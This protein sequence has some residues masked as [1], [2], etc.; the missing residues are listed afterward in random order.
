MTQEEQQ[1]GAIHCEYVPDICTWNDP[2]DH[3]RNWDE[4]SKIMQFMYQS[5]QVQEVQPPQPAQEDGEEDVP[6]QVRIVCD[7]NRITDEV[8]KQRIVQLNLQDKTFTPQKTFYSF[9]QTAHRV[10]SPPFPETRPQV[11]QL[12]VMLNNPQKNAALLE[13]KRRQLLANDPNYQADPNDQIENSSVSALRY[14]LIDFANI[15]LN[16]IRK[17]QLA[18]RL[19]KLIYKWQSGVPNLN[20]AVGAMLLNL[21]PRHAVN[22][23]A[24]DLARIRDNAM[25]L[26][27]EYMQHGPN[28]DLVE[29][30]NTNFPE[31]DMQAVVF[32]YD[33][34]CD[35][36]RQK[37]IFCRLHMQETQGQITHL[38]E[39]N[40]LKK[41]SSELDNLIQR[42]QTYRPNEDA[43][44]DRKIESVKRKA[45]EIINTYKEFVTLEESQKSR[46]KAKLILD[47]LVLIF[48]ECESL[49]IAGINFDKQTLGVDPNE[50][51]TPIETLSI[52]IENEV[53]KNKQREQQMQINAKQFTAHMPGIM[54]PKLH[55]SKDYLNFITNYTAIKSSIQDKLT[56]ANLIKSCLVK[57][58]DIEYLAT[59]Y[60][61][62][63]ILTYIRE[64][65]ADHNL[66]VQKSLDELYAMKNCGS[67]VACM[68][69]N[70]DKFRNLLKLFQIHHLL[71]K[72]DR[73]ARDRLFPKLFLDWQMLMFAHEQVKAEQRWRIADKSSNANTEDDR[74]REGEEFL[75]PSSSLNANNM[76]NL[77][78]RSRQDQRRQERMIEQQNACIEETNTLDNYEIGIGEKIGDMESESDTVLLESRRRKFFIRQH[79]R[80]YEAAMKIKTAEKVQLDK[81]DEKF[82][83]RKQTQG[84]FTTQ[85][86]G[87]PRRPQKQYKCPMFSCSKNGMHR[88]SLVNCATF[89]A[90]NRDEKWSI[91]SK[92][93][94][95]VCKRCLSYGHNIGEHSIVNGKCPTQ[96]KYRNLYCKNNYCIRAGIQ[97]NH[98][99]HICKFGETK[100][101]Q[102]IVHAQKDGF[103]RYNPKIRLQ[104]NY[105]QQQ[106]F[107]RQQNYGIQNQGQENQKRYSQSSFRGQTRGTFPNRGR[108]NF[109]TNNTFPNR[110][111]GN[112]QTNNRTP[113]TDRLKPGPGPKGSPGDSSSRGRGGYNRGGR[114]QYKRQN[115]NARISQSQKAYTTHT[116]KIEKDGCENENECEM[117]C[118]NPM[119]SVHMIENVSNN[120]ETNEQQCYMVRDKKVYLIPG[121][122]ESVPTHRP[123]PNKIEQSTIISQKNKKVKWVKHEELE[124]KVK[125]NE[126]NYETITWS[127]KIPQSKLGN[128]DKRFRKEISLTE[129][130]LNNPDNNKESFK[131]LR[132]QKRS[133][134]DEDSPEI[135][136][137]IEDHVRK[138]NKNKIEIGISGLEDNISTQTGDMNYLIDREKWGTRDKKNNFSI[139]E[140]TLGERNYKD[141]C[142]NWNWRINRP[143]YIGDRAKCTTLFCRN[144]VPWKDFKCKSCFQKIEK[145]NTMWRAPTEPKKYKMS[146]PEQRLQSIKR[147]NRMHHPKKKPNGSIIYGRKESKAWYPEKK[148]EEKLEDDPAIVSWKIM[149]ET[150][151]PNDQHNFLWLAKDKLYFNE[152]N[153]EWEEINEDISGL[154]IL[155]TTCH[156]LEFKETNLENT[157]RKILKL[158]SFGIIDRNG[159]SKLI[160]TKIETP[161]K[162]KDYNMNHIVQKQQQC[163]LFQA[164]ERNEKELQ[165]Y[166]V[167]N[168]IKDIN[169]LDYGACFNISSSCSLKAYDGN[170]YDGTIM[171]DGGATMNLV[172]DNIA[173]K[174]GFQKIGTGWEGFVRTLHGKEWQVMDSFLVPIW[175]YQDQK[176]IYIICQGI[177]GLR[178]GRPNYYP[179][180][181][182]RTICKAAGVPLKRIDIPSKTSYYDVLLGL[183]SFQHHP[184]EYIVPQM[185]YLKQKH[186]NI[187]FL[188]P[189]FC[190]GII[191]SGSLQKRN[192][193]ILENIGNQTLNRK[194][195]YRG[196]YGRCGPNI[197]DKTNDQ[198]YMVSALRKSFKEQDKK[199]KSCNYKKFDIQEDSF[200]DIYDVPKLMKKSEEIDNE[201]NNFKIDM[202]KKN[203]D[204]ETQ[205]Q[206]PKFNHTTHPQAN[207]ESNYNPSEYEEYMTLDAQ[208]KRFQRVSVIVK[209]DKKSTFAKTNEKDRT[210]SYPLTYSFMFQGITWRATSIKHNNIHCEL[211]SICD[212]KTCEVHKKI[213]DLHQKVWP[214][215]KQIDE[216]YKQSNE[217]N[218]LYDEQL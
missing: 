111:R 63:N 41:L 192:N 66:I 98:S 108:G 81:M 156:I 59:E 11:T 27:T 7:W 136:Y 119:Q 22:K 211:K 149:N 201:L 209:N 164:E 218:S 195:R 185:T 62:E 117:A 65:Y 206:Q 40:K 166:Q 77:S 182:Y 4:Y 84:V 217:N 99:P 72:I 208:P 196:I 9:W 170:F 54:L 169:I 55:D 202:S 15:C 200:L 92:M 16:V 97:Y 112:F 165:N 125:V 167:T 140:R 122:N 144:Q 67:S 213:R 14:V 87:N 75:T 161:K 186:P 132:E 91:I 13:Y 214:Q 24:T 102:K 180:E 118:C 93:L 79:Y 168:K 21:S 17:A 162:E 191:I 18:V 2:Q 76:E 42:I 50:L 32:N 74:F 94:N 171:F 124:K 110:G 184:K 194:P 154:T 157:D 82:H 141:V 120:E 70:G 159:K 8:F 133:W 95:R 58:R 147:Q 106:T 34:F 137:R 96:A 189:K 188:E 155:D 101:Y 153:E 199:D 57:K 130:S 89:R 152:V 126:N 135:A 177:R 131:Q 129:K 150:S 5:M 30:M 36:I 19:Y 71:P 25:S 51:K 80:C 148:N 215:E 53:L 198:I 142:G 48:K 37:T 28:Y 47:T 86:Y 46:S 35:T 60:N 160:N 88:K 29:V 33:D 52:W 172:D 3:P 212:P 109:Q 163:N 44:Q 210:N 190:K 123:P 12:N 61:P 73:I 128:L 23:N 143:D 145:S 20:A 43:Q 204:T 197:V 78:E 100:P 178:D 107:S 1:R 68:I 187:K 31:S 138:L 151:K 203:D 85:T 38:L 181:F 115:R 176:I 64:H 121:L 139:P 83:K 56:M 69:S 205:S 183:P 179:E 6:A 207:Y 158:K 104:R 26:F 10:R 127:K 193:D 146:F 103:S 175:S 105:Q 134:K 113:N 116:T 49:D 39:E 173:R 114:G 174:L 45:K 90:M 216:I